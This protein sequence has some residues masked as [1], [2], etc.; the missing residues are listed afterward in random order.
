MF[1]KDND[2]NH[3]VAIDFKDIKSIEDAQLK[4]PYILFKNC[5]PLQYLKDFYDNP[6]DLYITQEPMNDLSFTLL[7]ILEAAHES[8]NPESVIPEKEKISPAHSDRIYG[9]VANRWN[10]AAENY[11]KEKEKNEKK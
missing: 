5:Y 10:K 7:V 9:E 3:S 11:R 2:G 1:P 4:M 6:L 8:L